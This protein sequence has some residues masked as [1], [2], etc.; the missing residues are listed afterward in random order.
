[1]P[2][3]NPGGLTDEQMVGQLFIGYVYGSS[4]TEVTPAQRAANLALYGVA[5]G[6]E[7][8]HR[9]HLGGI[10]LIGQN[11]LDPQ[12]ADL[13][14]DNVDSAGQ[15]RALTA[16]LQRAATGSGDPPLLIGTDQEGGSVQRIT[17]GV[18]ARPSQEQ[19]AQQ[20]DA[21]QIRCSYR[22]LG[23]Q[24]RALGVNQDYAPDA[25]VIRVSG[26]VIG[27]RSFGPDPAVDARDVL[28]ATQGLQDAGVLATLK[29]WPGH[30]GTT[31]DSHS[32][33]P[34]VRESQAQWEALDRV[35][36]AAAASTAGAVMVG[37]L[38]Y[39]AIDP[40]SVPAT[41]SPPL[42]VGQLLRG[43]N[44]QGVVLTDSLWMA[45]VL[46]AGSAAQVAVR[47]IQSGDDMLLMSPDVPAAYGAILN[48]MYTDDAFRADV[49]AAVARILHAKAV[50]AT[51]PRTP[52]C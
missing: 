21:A 40:A 17:N 14:S 43:L 7:I 24:M 22:Q 44:Y 28:A 19:L 6:A 8:V 30:G 34:V 25:D 35:P 1:L 13:W 12:R 51:G 32:A 50:V 11:T 9:W 48:R 39:P 31:V 29:H 10:I 3:P 38:A 49:Q 18:S 2:A 16:G 4:A 20:L 46:Q 36:F 37:H 45:P 5:T 42:V 15:I 26:G 33:L 27:D 23:D 52:S 47:G 41:L